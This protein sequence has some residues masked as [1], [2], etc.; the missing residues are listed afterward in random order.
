MIAIKPNGIRMVFGKFLHSFVVM[1]VLFF[2]AVEIVEIVAELDS[3]VYLV[4]AQNRVCEVEHFG[5]KVSVGD[6]E[7]FSH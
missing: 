7:D 4:L 1:F 2:I 6:N 3:V 5:F